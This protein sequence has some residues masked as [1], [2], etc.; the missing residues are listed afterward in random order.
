MEIRDILNQ[1]KMTFLQFIS[2]KTGK[3][4]YF[5]TIE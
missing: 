4:V 1:L 5:N 3:N 2:L